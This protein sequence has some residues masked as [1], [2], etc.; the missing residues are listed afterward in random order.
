MEKTKNTS[1]YLEDVHIKYLALISVAHRLKKSEYLR[2]LIDMDME[3]NEEFVKTYEK[4][5]FNSNNAL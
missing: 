3:R 5:L 2:A 4:I 1:V